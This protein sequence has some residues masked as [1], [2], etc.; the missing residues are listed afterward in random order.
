AEGR[1]VSATY[2]SAISIRPGSLISEG[3]AFVRL[4]PAEERSM[5]QTDVINALRTELAQVPGMRA[6]ALD[7]STQGF[8][9]VRGYPVDPAVQGPDWK[10]TTEFAEEIRHRM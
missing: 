7:L 10:T 2:F 5:S 4:V 6:V 9:A 3:I 1:K 8:T